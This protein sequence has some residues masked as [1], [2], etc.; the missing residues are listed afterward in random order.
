MSFEKKDKNQ[1]FKR[2]EV[3]KHCTEDDCWIIVNGKVVDVGEFLSDHPGGFF[4]IEPYYGKD[5][6]IAFR[7]K[8][9]SEYARSLLSKFQIGVTNELSEE[10]LKS[11]EPKAKKVIDWEEFQENSNPD[12]CW[13]LLDD[14]VYDVTRLEG[15]PGEYERVV[16]YSSIDATD[17]VDEM[18]LCKT[19][20]AKLKE[21]VIGVIDKDTMPENAGEFKT[22]SI[23]SMKIVFLL[24]FIG[25]FVRVIFNYWF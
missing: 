21:N 23:F 18:N 22:S 24:I 19:T 9:H 3:S 5:A 12:S 10:E 14:Q 4:P 15:E 7:D 1:F 2:E 13:I 11:M 8:P 25:F 20:L 17:R 6:T 16:R